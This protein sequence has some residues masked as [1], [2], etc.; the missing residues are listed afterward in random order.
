MT[1]RSDEARLTDLELK[2]MLEADRLEKL[3]GVV[4]EQAKLIARLEREVRELSSR[5]AEL[6]AG[7]HAPAEKPPHW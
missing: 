5:L 7:E 4:W 2:Y 1:A 6:P 3:S